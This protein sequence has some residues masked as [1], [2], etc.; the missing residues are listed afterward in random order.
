MATS[1][2][3]REYF[4][5]DPQLLSQILY[6]FLRRIL[7]NI[8]LS[9]FH[10]TTNLYLLDRKT[11]RTKQWWACGEA[12]CSSGVQVCTGREQFFSKCLF[13]PYQHFKI[14]HLWTIAKWCQIKSVLFKNYYRSI[15]KRFEFDAQSVASFCWSYNQ[16]T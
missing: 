9:Q 10:V 12:S 13:S 3:S 1:A 11:Q 2:A 7:A 16:V 4:H 6:H 15:N 5:I 8:L 14:S